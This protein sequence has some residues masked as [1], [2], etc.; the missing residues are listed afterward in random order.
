MPHTPVPVDQAK[1]PICPDC[2]K[3]VFRAD[4]MVMIAD[5]DRK[6]EGTFT[7]CMHC[8]TIWEVAI[9]NDGLMLRQPTVAQLLEMPRQVQEAAA[10]CAFKRVIAARM[11][12]PLEEY[13]VLEENVFGK[14][15]QV[16]PGEKAN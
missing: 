7:V 13:L 15:W 12:V 4:R 10:L 8:S 11:G 2:K 9:V 6:R 5:L 3:P 14:P 1:P 16:P